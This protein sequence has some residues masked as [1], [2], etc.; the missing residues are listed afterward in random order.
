MHAGSFTAGPLARGGFV[1]RATLPFEP[2]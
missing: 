2:A 1:V